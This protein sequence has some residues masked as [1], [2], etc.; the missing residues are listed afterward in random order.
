RICS[1][2]GAVSFP[3]NNSQNPA[4]WLPKETAR[5]IYIRSALHPE[6]E[7]NL[8]R[9]VNNARYL[10]DAGCEFQ[11]LYIAHPTRIAKIPEYREI[12]GR[13]GLPFTPV[14]FIGQYKGRPY[15][16]SYS[17]EEKRLVGLEE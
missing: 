14:A 13:H 5:R 17:E 1:S 16:H 4:R 9:Y 2:H 11:S 6:S 12:F 7:P 15:P 10:I 8:D 3:T